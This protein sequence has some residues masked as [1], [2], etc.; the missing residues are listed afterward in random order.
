MNIYMVTDDYYLFVGVSYAL[1]ILAD[2]SVKKIS[3]QQVLSL[4]NSNSLTNDDVFIICCNCDGFNLDLLIYL[5]GISVRIIVVN[6]NKH[7]S[8]HKLFGFNYLP[9]R[10]RLEELI[11]SYNKRDVPT[12]IKLKHGLR[13]IEKKILVSVLSKEE[14]NDMHDYSKITP[15]RLS[16]YK[17]SMVRKLGLRNILQLHMLPSSIIEYI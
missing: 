1:K 12:T 9:A 5:E 17:R 10:F 7:W 11:F 16:Y 15:K 6:D 13:M 2:S 8:L 14:C 3:E 4:V